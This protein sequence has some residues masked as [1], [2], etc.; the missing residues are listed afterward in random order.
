MLMDVWSLMHYMG[1]RLM[2]ISW[3]KIYNMAYIRSWI[4]GN[5][6]PT[7]KVLHVNGVSSMDIILLS[8]INLLGVRYA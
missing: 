1:C 6:D 5:R 8:V 4:P 3:R 2:K 7:M